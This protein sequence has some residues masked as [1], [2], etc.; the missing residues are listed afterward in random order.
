MLRPTPFLRSKS[1]LTASGFQIIG[2]SREE[3]YLRFSSDT[4]LVERVFNT[5]LEDFGNGK[6]A[7]LTEPEI[8]AQFAG[9]V[10][11]ILGLHNLGSLEPDYESTIC[12]EAIIGRF[13]PFRKRSARK[14]ASGPD[15]SLGNGKF[16]FGP[17]DFYTFD[18][19]T[20]L[21]EGGNTGANGSDCIGIFANTNIYKEPAQATILED[22][23]QLFSQD[24]AF[25][26]D[27]N[28][29]INFI[30]G[31]RPG[32]Y[33]PAGSISRPT[34][35]SRPAHLIAPGAPITL[36]VT[37]PGKFSFGQN[38]ADAVTAMTSPRTNVRP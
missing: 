37:N 28:I 27:P 24:T 17:P 2:G 19:E 23:F 25:S 11:D 13:R 6:F 15:Y 29:T 32:S 35:I 5:Q 36:Y 16:A 26:T 8:P 10:S 38:L 12:N 20:P 30:R 33:R 9:V 31:G 18:D 1:W 14:S 22:Y 4:A 21:L 3:G 7:N 34:W